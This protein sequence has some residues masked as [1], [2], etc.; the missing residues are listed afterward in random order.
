MIGNKTI[1]FSHKLYNSTKAHEIMAMGE[2]ILCTI[3]DGHAIPV[4]EWFKE[5][6]RDVA[7]SD[8]Q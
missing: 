8:E 1:K 2:V 4:P 6:H 3:L 5:E 7:E